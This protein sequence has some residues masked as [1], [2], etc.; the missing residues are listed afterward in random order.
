[1]KKVEILLS[2]FLLTGSLY[3]QPGKEDQQRYAIKLDSSYLFI[4]N[5]NNRWY[6]LEFETDTIF[7]IEGN[8]YFFNKKLI[9]VETVS[10]D[11][12]KKKAVYGSVKNEKKALDGFKDW[13]L[14]YQKEA[15]QKRLKSGKEYYTNQNGKPFLIWWFETP[16]KSNVPN[17]EIE[18]NL[19]SDNNDESEVVDS[20][21]KEWFATHQLFLNFIIHGNTVISISTP[22]LENETLA[23][24]INKLK[25]IAN[26]LNVYGSYIN[27]KILDEKIK[28]RGNAVV[29]DS[30]GSIKI[31]I[32]DWLNVVLQIRSYKNILF[33]TFPE[34]ENIINA[35]SIAWNYKTDSLDFQS[36][37]EKRQS[38]SRRENV[39]TILKK[40][41]ILREFCTEK[42]GRFHCQDV[43]IE[44]E[45]VFCWIHFVATPTTYD[46]NIDRFN[47]LVDKIKI[48]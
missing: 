15:L 42:D 6:S 41:N 10:L 32:P 11:V 1:M 31:E 28:N 39:K 22:V 2:F 8:I 36:Y 20:L 34:K 47:E 35:V 24:E 12:I 43:Y 23:G 7:N 48:K 30:L 38:N 18:V 17:R 21:S 25:T 44:G 26:T 16:L 33:A 4:D 29:S 14:N 46:F 45:M 5:S 27:F 3:A 9:Q 13:E 19:S 40:D 37:I